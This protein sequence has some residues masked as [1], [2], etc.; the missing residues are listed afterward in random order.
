MMSA[1]ILAIDLGIYK[2]VACVYRCG[3]EPTFTILASNPK[4]VLRLAARHRP[5]VVAAYKLAQVMHQ[6]MRFGEASVNR[7]ALTGRPLARP[8]PG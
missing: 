2:S 7:P 1:T 3:A 8:P 5:G 4:S 6:L